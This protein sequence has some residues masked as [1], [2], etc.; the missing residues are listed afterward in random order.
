MNS[1]TK[2]TVIAVAA[3]VVIVAVAYGG[4]IAY[5]GT[6]SPFYTVESGSMSHTNGDRSQI[7][8][9]DTGDMVLARDPSKMSVTTYV[10][11][12]GSGYMRFGDYGDVII[13][14]RP[15]GTPVIHRTILYVESNGD[16]T[17]NIPS[18]VDY[19]GIWT[20]NDDPGDPDDAGALA[21]RL[22]FKYFGFSGEG[23]FT[24][25]LD[26][27]TPGSGYITKGDAN[28]GADQSTMTSMNKLIGAD[29]IIAIA[30]HEIPWLGAIKLYVTGNN[31]GAI[32][33]NTLP[34]LIA[35][36][37]LIF[38]SMI[39]VGLVYERFEKKGR[40]KE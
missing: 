28:D 26:T 1:E 30:A 3:A 27:L 32:P 39:T 12:H 36:F 33:S 9:I 13:Y 24:V 19:T 22:G 35:S 17:W 25:N 8:I 11:G 4:I 5:S 20:I 34:S 31:T 14:G 6:S 2:R 7:G 15:S 16:G 21:G 23:S 37:V 40:K 18:L 29:S 10:E 38:L